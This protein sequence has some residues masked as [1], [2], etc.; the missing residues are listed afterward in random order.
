MN[1]FTV[2]IPARYAASRLPGKLLRDLAKKPVVLH[3]IERGLESGA[4]R[5][6]VA[7][8][9]ARIAQ[10]VE[11][12]GAQTVMT[13]MDH[14]SGTDRI[15]EAVE[16]LGLAEG[17]IVVNVQGDEPDMPAAL[18][19]QMADALAE[20]AETSICTACTPISEAESVN[21][22]NVVKVVRDM[23][24]FALYFSR[25]PIAYDR[26]G[27][28]RFAYRRHLGIYAYRARY[29]TEFSAAPVCSLE[30]TEKLEQLRALH[31]GDRI[32]CPDAIAAPGIGIDTEADLE[33]ARRHWKS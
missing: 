30:E 6:V 29:L 27:L 14:Q 3:A 2:I 21:D 16:R 31:R 7:T 11:G 15:A 8:D 25:A 4:H 26:D 1:D 17:E 32:Y 28:G 12:S 18:I 33:R 19:R 20:R 22:P 5:V 10:A 23:N 13:R 9:D 24:D